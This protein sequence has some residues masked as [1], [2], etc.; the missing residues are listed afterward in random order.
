MADDLPD[1][2]L[3]LYTNVHEAKTKAFLEPFLE[4]SGEDKPDEED[5]PKDQESSTED[6]DDGQTG[7]ASPELCSE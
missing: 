2:I 7:E 6:T 5:Q 3:S 4:R 1:S